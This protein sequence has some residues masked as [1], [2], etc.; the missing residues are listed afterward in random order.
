MIL[1]G[2]IQYSIVRYCTTTPRTDDS[3]PTKEYILKVFVMC[4]ATADFIHTCSFS[5][6]QMAHGSSLD[7]SSIVNIFGSISFFF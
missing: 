3:R 4:M 2:L 1:L 7:S 5:N 6:Y